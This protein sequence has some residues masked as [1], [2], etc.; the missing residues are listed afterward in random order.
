MLRDVEIK[1]GK[2]GACGR[3]KIGGNNDVATQ[4]EGKR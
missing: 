1:T 2:T 3:T 4:L